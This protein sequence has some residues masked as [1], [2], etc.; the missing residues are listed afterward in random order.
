LGNEPRST[1]VALAVKRAVIWPPRFL[2]RGVKV[3]V[4]N[5]D[6]RSQGNTERLDRAIQI[7]VIDRVFIVPDSGIWPR[8]LVANE[9][10]TVVTRIRLD[11][12]HCRVCP[13]LD[14]GLHSNCGSLSC[15]GES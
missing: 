15:K 4:T 7:F 1:A 6:P 14:C 8:D 11:L 5:I 13:G 9:E 12:V 2:R 10:N 3:D